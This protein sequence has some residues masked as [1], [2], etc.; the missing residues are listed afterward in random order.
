MQPPEYRT[1]QRDVEA[2][3]VPYGESVTIP[4][5]TEVCITHFLGGNF[6]VTWNHNMAQILGKDADAIGEEIQSQTNKTVSNHKGPPT[7]ESLWD[8]L[9]LVFDPE[10]P[11][12]IVDLGLVY[13]LDIDKTEDELYDIR[14]NM[15]L[16]A[17]GCGMGPVI[18]QD[19][20]YKLESVPGVN[21]A[22][23]EIVWDPPWTQ[24]MISEDGKM[25]LGLI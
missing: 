22:T 19:A 12:N 6:T 25:E 20:K 13:S 14:C 15:T 23:V 16:T 9:K 4:E 1:L 11:V 18:A 3:L 5:G 21:E 24:D 10:I 7:Q 8:A 17:P 2:T